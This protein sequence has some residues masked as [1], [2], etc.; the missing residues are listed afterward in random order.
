MSFLT[1][2]SCL[3]AISACLMITLM[4]F[5]SI[6]F[7]PREE[8]AA[9]TG[10]GWMSSV[11]VALPMATVGCL[12][13]LTYCMMVIAS[14]EDTPVPGSRWASTEISFPLAGLFARM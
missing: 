6:R 10:A 8:N 14:S 4:M 9:M 11:V 13:V 3:A 2:Y 5:G 1:T 12:V 7:G